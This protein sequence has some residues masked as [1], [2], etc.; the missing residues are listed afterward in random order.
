MSQQINLNELDKSGDV[1]Q[2]AED[3]GVDRST[4]L[5]NGAIAGAGAVG[6]GIF[7]LPSLADATISSKKKSV[8]NDIKILN[9]A[10]LLEYL[11]SSYYKAAVAQNTFASPAIA[12]FAQVVNAHE[13]AHVDFLKKGLG[14][15]AIAVPKLNTDAVK[16]AI[17]VENFAKTAMALEDTGVSAYAGQGPNLK[18]RAFVVAALQIHS[19]EA[20]H[21]AWIR[22][23]LLPADVNA[24]STKA[25]PAPVSFDKAR[26]EGAVAKIVASTKLVKSY[27]KSKI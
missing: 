14:K 17:S 10:L 4:F 2:I 21:A 6:L 3:S 5:R 22:T 18:T 25:L 24:A 23:L 12:Q 11:E 19:V 9:Y 20:R 1:R 13:K 15:S 26:S 8:K 27:D 16:T 7:G